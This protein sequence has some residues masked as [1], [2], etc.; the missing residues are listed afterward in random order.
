MRDFF[1]IEQEETKS[2]DSIPTPEEKI[3]DIFYS[4]DEV[5]QYIEKVGNSLRHSHLG[6]NIDIS[7]LSE[8]QLQQ[9]QTEKQQRLK[10]CAQL[11]K[12]VYKCFSTLFYFSQFFLDTL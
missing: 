8:S 11:N 5:F 10:L 12:D 2:S 7:Q 3:Q 6:S 1:H 9:F 4:S